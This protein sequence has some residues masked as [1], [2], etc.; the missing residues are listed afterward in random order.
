MKSSGRPPVEPLRLANSE[1]FSARDEILAGTRAALDVYGRRAPSAFPPSAQVAT[2]EPGNRLAEIGLMLNT[3]EAL[4]GTTGQIDDA[5]EFT[6]ALKDLVR[7]E[8]IKT[9][10]LWTNA[11]MR[12]FGV[13]KALRQLGV[14]LVPADADRGQLARCDLG[15]T[16]ADAVLPQT[17]TLVL[18]SSA[19]QLPVVS[20]LPRVHLAI[21]RPAAL[22]ADLSQAFEQLKDDKH[23]VL[24]SGPSRT[25]DIEKVLTLGVHGPKSLYVWCWI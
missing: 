13:E 4:G 10:T 2:R 8:A 17:G 6:L 23:F 24:I 1:E 22:C 20:L 21:F 12:E 18:R 9:A 15:V 19:E 3:V 16:G 5:A 14:E 7:R 25:T 11:E